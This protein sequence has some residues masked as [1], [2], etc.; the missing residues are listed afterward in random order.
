MSSVIARNQNERKIKPNA[1]TTGT[2]AITEI[3][4]PRTPGDYVLPTRLA[5]AVL[6][7]PKNGRFFWSAVL[8]LGSHV[9]IGVLVIRLP[10]IGSDQNLGSIRASPIRCEEST[11]VELSW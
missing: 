2:H 8:R 4:T 7:P 1:A 11:F 3:A 6:S 10:G 5:A 9:R